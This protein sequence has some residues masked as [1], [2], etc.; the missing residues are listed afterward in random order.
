[1]CGTL[2]K[3]RTV[4]SKFLKNSEMYTTKKWSRRSLKLTVTSLRNIKKSNCAGEALKINLISISPQEES[5]KFSI[6]W[7][8]FYF[9]PERG[10]L[11]WNKKKKYIKQIM[12]KLTWTQ[13]FTILS[14]LRN[15]LKIK[16][17]QLQNVLPTLQV[18]LRIWWVTIEDASLIKRSNLKW[19][20]A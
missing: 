16:I 15:G 19:S 20:T 1:M 6:N 13:L 7:A 4:I 5:G 2:D 12:G 10:H 17:S 8:T 3:S 9:V 14:S 18:T 11:L